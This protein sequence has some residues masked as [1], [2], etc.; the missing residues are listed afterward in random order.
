MRPLL[1]AILA[2]GLSSRMGGRDKASIVLEDGQTMLEHVA[3]ALRLA[4]E[5][6]DVAVIVGT[7][8]NAAAPGHALDHVMVPDV[9]EQAGPLG[10]I[11]ALLASGLAREYLVC[12]CDMPWITAEVLRVLLQRREAT[13]TVLRISGTNRF[14][15]LP[16]RIAASA[17]PLVR[18]QLDAG[19]RPVWQLMER[20]PAAV[21]DIDARHAP[22]LR[23]I[24]TPDDLA[25]KD[26]N[27]A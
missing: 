22:S 12:P 11:E 17:L 10:G 14:D 19:V 2:G 3:A 13:A 21:I 15:P 25:A 6:D 7:K 16:A 26:L 5:T 1:G 27:M 8:A 9:R 23:N 18:E 24:N 20:M 4:C